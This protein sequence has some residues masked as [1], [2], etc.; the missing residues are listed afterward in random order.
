MDTQ[1]DDTTKFHGWRLIGVIMIVIVVLAAISAL[2][3]W[4]TFR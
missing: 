3:D 4:L 2:V 1:D